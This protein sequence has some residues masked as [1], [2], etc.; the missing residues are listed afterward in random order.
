MTLTFTSKQMYKLSALI[1][2]LVTSHNLDHTLKPGTQSNSYHNG[3]IPKVTFSEMDLFKLKNRQAM[4][5]CY[6]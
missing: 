3:D 6:R 4:D 5:I 2:A 1:F